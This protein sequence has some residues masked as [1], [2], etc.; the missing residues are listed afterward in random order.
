MKMLK[1]KYEWGCSKAA[2]VS[3]TSSR[4]REIGKEYLN[5]K[6]FYG[7]KGRGRSVKIKKTAYYNEKYA[8]NTI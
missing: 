7:H 5:L 4:N 8:V 6:K 3:I 2:G 1:V